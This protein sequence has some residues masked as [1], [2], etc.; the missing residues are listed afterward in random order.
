MIFR[1]DLHD[2]LVAAGKACLSA[3]NA[4]TKNKRAQALREVIDSIQKQQPHLF[5]SEQLAET[6]ARQR[7]ELDES[8]PKGAL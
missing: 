3:T 4:A 6:A 5:R 2:H 8:K 1:K 7:K